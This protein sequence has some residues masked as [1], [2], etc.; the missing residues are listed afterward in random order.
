MGRHTSEQYQEVED[1]FSNWD[2]ANL[3]AS[4]LQDYLII[5]A[6]Q[7]VHN[8]MVRHREIIRGITIN[9]I[10]MQKHIESLERKNR[11]MTWAVGALTIASLIATL[12]QI[13]LPFSS[14]LLALVAA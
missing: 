5:L 10:L 6:N 13:A 1:S 8:E 12:V 9:N 14:Q 7:P 4:K 2:I 11:L 3:P